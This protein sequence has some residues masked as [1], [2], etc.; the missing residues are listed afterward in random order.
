MTTKDQHLIWRKYLVPW[1]DDAAT[2]KGNI[3]VY[4]KETNKEKERKSICNI[5]CEKYTYDISSITE[6]DK[7]VIQF[8]FD[9]WL[10][11][12][13]NFNLKTAFVKSDKILERDYIEHNYIGVIEQKGIKMLQDLYVGRFPFDCP[14][15]LDQVG[16]FLK[17]NILNRL[18]SNDKLFS[19]DEISLLCDCALSQYDWVDKRYDFF[20]FLSVQMLRTWRSKENI[21]DSINKTIEKFNDTSLKGTTQ[22]MFPLM[23]MVNSQILASALCKRNFYIELLNN[24]TE[25]RFITGDFPII[26]LYA[27]YDK[28]DESLDKMELY[29]PL[30]PRIA[31]ICKNTISSNTT[32]TITSVCETDELNKK[33]F[34]AAKK[35]VYAKCVEDLRMYCGK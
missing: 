33:I 30:T 2:T 28:V 1:T 10:Q 8:Y 22:A 29:Y 25:H 35:E 21:F 13:S 19:D 14:T 4:Y 12:Q 5:G 24:E 6:N 31:I 15:I 16:E 32:R 18:L 9:K 7:K 17:F 34:N 27:D 23:M 26:N 20:E 3:A 11:T